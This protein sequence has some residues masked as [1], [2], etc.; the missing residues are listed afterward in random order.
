M[1][2]QFCTTPTPLV[3]LAHISR[4]FGANLFLKM[5]TCNP[6][7]NAW[8]R[9][10]LGCL[11]AALARGELG[12][13][14]HV[15]DAADGGMA[16]GLALAANALDLRLTLC[17]PP[18]ASPETA[19]LLRKAGAAPRATKLGAGMGA[20]RAEAEALQDDCWY[21]F[22]P[23]LFTNPDAEKACAELGK[24]VLEQ[25]G[26]VTRPNALVAAVTTGATL[27]GAGGAILRDARACRLVAV[28]PG[29]AAP[30][31]Q[32]GASAH[33]EAAGAHEIPAILG[34]SHCH[35]AIFVPLD[36]AAATAQK[37][38]AQ[39]GLPGGSSTGAV[40][41]AMITLAGR[42]EFKGK[43]IVGVAGDSPGLG[44]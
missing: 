44:F 15:V 26:P 35:E 8:M 24:E 6:Y 33:G 42:P 34:R 7:G 1:Y 10:A 30:G 9:H 41:H 21:S 19:A 36:A 13:S 39:E 17:L 20:A 40:L 43:T 31:S 28:V 32:P 12:P 5:E 14:G 38:F 23:D 4:V 27:A 11:G 18:E 3:R 37:L 25:L 22:R 2:A 29:Q 16:L